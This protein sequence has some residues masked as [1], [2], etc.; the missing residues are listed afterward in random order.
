MVVEVIWY[1]DLYCCLNQGREGG[2]LREK[3]L[4]QETFA[5]E[6]EP[7]TIQALHGLITLVHDRVSVSDQIRPPQSSSTNGSADEERMKMTSLHSLENDQVAN[8]IWN[9]EPCI[10]QKVLL[11]MAVSFFYSPIKFTRSLKFFFMEGQEISLFKL[12]SGL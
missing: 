7:C 3:E 1:I 6:L 11:A 10:L 8:F 2:D 9:L 5:R 12:E 4:R